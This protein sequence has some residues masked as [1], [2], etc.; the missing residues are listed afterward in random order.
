MNPDNIL[1]LLRYLVEQLNSLVDHNVF[2]SLIELNAGL[3]AVSVTVVA[4][5]PTLVELVRLKYPSFLSAEVARIRLI[6]AL[7]AISRTIWMFGIAALLSLIGLMFKL[8]AM[9]VLATLLATVGIFILIKAS[10]NVAKISISI[11][12]EK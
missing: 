4:L 3:L 6:K 2:G 7:K 11:I 9:G 8:Q 12:E 5:V 1:T 10:L